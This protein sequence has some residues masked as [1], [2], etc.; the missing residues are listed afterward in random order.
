[1]RMFYGLDRQ[2]VALQSPVTMYEALVNLTWH[3]IQYKSS[4]LIPRETKA[5]YDV[6][7]TG[8]SLS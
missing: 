5:S 6:N 7:N 8:G 1:M 4:Q 3:Y 2:L